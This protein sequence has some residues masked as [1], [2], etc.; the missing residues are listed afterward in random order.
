MKSSLARRLERLEQALGDEPLGEVRIYKGR[1]EDQPDY[2]PGINAT[3][4]PN[5]EGYVII[6]IPDNGRPRKTPAE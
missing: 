1:L 4:S 6:W 2:T 3:L 5:A